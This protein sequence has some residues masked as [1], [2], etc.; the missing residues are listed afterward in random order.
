MLLV[1]LTVFSVQGNV[2]CQ[3]MSSSVFLTAG[4]NEGFLGVVKMCIHEG[5]AFFWERL[6]WVICK[7]ESIC[8][9]HARLL[10]GEL[11]ILSG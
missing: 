6:L 8:T 3:V 9:S 2:L 7:D 10:S 4:I 5:T 1:N 11:Q